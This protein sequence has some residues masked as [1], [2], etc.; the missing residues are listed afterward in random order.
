MVVADIARN[1]YFIDDEFCNEFLHIDLRTLDNCLKA[2]TGCDWVFNLAA[3]MG[4]MGF[5]ESNHSVILWNNTMIS[6]NMLEAARRN[7]CKRFFYSSTACIYP[8]H[9]QT[10]EDVAGLCEDNAWLG[11]PQGAYGLEKLIS[12]E[13][14]MHYGRD[15]PLIVHTAR[16]HNIYG[17]Q[18]T[19][20]GGREKAPAAFCRKVRVAHEGLNNGEVQIWGDGNQTRSFC[21]IDDCVEGILRIMMSDYDRPL[22]LGSDELVSVNEICDIV[23]EIEGIVVTKKHIPGPEGVRGRNSDNTRIREVLNWAPS[24][25]LKDGIRKT[26]AW[27]K[28]RLEKER[29]VV[30]IAHYADSI[31]VAQTTDSLQDIGKVIN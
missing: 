12:E 8:E 28:S 22:N 7:G 9:I 14:A 3:D 30:S 13:I 16:F 2:S 29:L 11:K 6:F 31:I 15:F 19:W 27:I 18:G 4:G 23:A 21:Y 24:I 25:S 1:E 17:P 20:K 10:K 26:Y 5:I